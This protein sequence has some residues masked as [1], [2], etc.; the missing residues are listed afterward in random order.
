MPRRRGFTLIELLVVIAIIAVLIALFL[1]AV[2]AARGAARR[3]QCLN[4]LKQVGL[5]LQNYH[6]AVGTFPMSYAARS[7]FKNG[8]TDTFPGWGW[9][10]LILPQLEQGVLFGAVNFNSSV[11]D[12]GNTTVVGTILTVY[13]CPSDPIPGGPFAVMDGS[14][15]TLAS[16]GPS[17]YAACVGDDLADTTTG[18]SNDGMGNG[19]LFRNSGIRIADITDGTSQT[20]SVGERAWSITS[21]PWAGVATLGVL[22][23]GPANPCPTSGAPFYPAASLVQAHC[24]VLNTDTDPDGG[25]DDFSS[26]H[27]GGANVVF[28]DGS[29]HFLKSVLRNS[30][31]KADGSTLYSPSSL[32]LQA[33]G[34]RAGSEVVSSEAY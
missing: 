7:P 32:V 13:L 23:R 14:G 22:R 31:T 9:G 25:I 17:S 19:I 4:N 21:G 10:T 6:D 27:P 16:L 5:A 28:A 29:V 34:T 12:L 15:V 30:G 18:L 24:N 2:Q 33:L 26:R 8:A 11:E 1:P 3:A 20:I